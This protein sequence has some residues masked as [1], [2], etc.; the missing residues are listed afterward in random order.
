MLQK[1]SDPIEERDIHKVLDAM[2]DERVQNKIMAI[3]GTRL[4]AQV[5]PDG[6]GVALQ[7][8]RKK[9]GS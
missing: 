6:K 3:V 5:M 8:S 1:G 4:T 9:E 7:I 2:D